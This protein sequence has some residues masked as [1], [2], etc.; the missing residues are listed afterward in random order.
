MPASPAR[1][2]SAALRLKIAALGRDARRVVDI[3]LR[4]HWLEEQR[5][6]FAR[7]P[8]DQQPV[9]EAMI[10]T[11][12]TRVTWH[13]DW[14]GKILAEDPDLTSQVATGTVSL[15]EAYRRLVGTRSAC[16]A[17]AA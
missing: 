11:L 16:C 15:E 2:V 9:A 3:L 6:L 8:P 14:I 13:L 5:R 10:S 1:D 4:D 12:P 7:L 17:I